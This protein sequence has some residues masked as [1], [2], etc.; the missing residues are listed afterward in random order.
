[1]RLG[2][3]AAMAAIVVCA[4]ASVDG[5]A[6][7]AQQGQNNQQ[8]QH[9]WNGWYGG[10]NLGGAFGGSDL[11]SALNSGVPFFEG[12]VYP[13]SNPAALARIREAYQS[14]SVNFKSFTGGI[15]G[16][17]NFYSGGILLGIEA[18]INWLNAQK[19]K[20]TSAVG[21]PFFTPGGA[22]LGV[23]T[24]T[25]RSEIDA[26]YLATLRPRIGMPVGNS[27]LY[28]TGGLALTTLNYKHSFRGT[29]GFF[30]GGPDITETAS[31]SKTVVGWTIGG[32][33]EVPLSSSISLKTEYLFTA[34][35]NVESRDNKIQPLTA[36]ATPPDFAC[37]VNTGQGGLFFGNPTIATPR[38]CFNHKADLFL[39]T[40][41]VGLNYKF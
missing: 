29:G 1:M 37:G 11:L 3:R 22:P 18:D 14:N 34:F 4:T 21:V 36:G 9:N 27:M 24:Y 31:A 6:A 19:A 30:T 23:T 39:H 8:S 10:G 7:L 38:Q 12:E 20:T 28:A 5:P 41:R 2:I 40:L 17:Y 26:N 13:S 16:G 35:G 33:L 25:F 15:Q 32:G